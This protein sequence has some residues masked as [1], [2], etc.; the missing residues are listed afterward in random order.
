MTNSLNDYNIK[1]L[2]KTWGQQSD[3]QCSIVA[4]P[5]DLQT[6]K[7]SSIQLSAS[8]LR[9]I[10]KKTPPRN[11]RLKEVQ[12]SWPQEC[13]VISPWRRIAHHP[14]KSIT[15][16]T[17]TVITRSGSP[18]QMKRPRF[19]IDNNRPPLQHL[20]QYPMQTPLKQQWLQF[21]RNRNT[22]MKVKGMDHH[23]IYEMA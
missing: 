2:L 11:I 3:D 20:H 23:D 8:V 12:H 21:V 14:K 15:H 4:L 6:I 17:G 16:T 13:L 5:A 1:V 19:R 22:S 10:Q 9:K 18:I 7:E